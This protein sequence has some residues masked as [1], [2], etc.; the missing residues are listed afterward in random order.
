MNWRLTVA[1]CT[2]G[3][4]LACVVLGQ[5]EKP[6]PADAGQQ[7]RPTAK[8]VG[9]FEPVGAAELAAGTEQ[10]K[11]LVIKQIVPHGTQVKQGQALVW[12]KTDEV[13]KQLEDAET[14]LRLA[15]LKQQEATFTH[16]QFLKIQA[17][18]LGLANR[19]KRDAQQTYDNFVKVDRDQRI[20]S[21]GFNL[22]S[23]K[24]S[25]ENAMEELKQLEKMY[26]E[27]ELTEES[28]EIVLKRAKRSVESAQFRL[29]VAEITAS[30]SLAQVIPRE[31]EQQDDTLARALLTFDKARRGL[32]LDRQR[33][34]IEAAKGRK[35]FAAQKQDVDKMRADRKQMV[36]RAASDGVVY[37]GTLSRGKLAEKPSS[38][39][40]ETTVTNKQ[41]LVTLVNPRALQIRVD[42]PETALRHVKAGGKGIAMPKAFPDRKLEI[43]V[44]SVSLIPMSNG[45]HDC[46][47]NVRLDGDQ[48]AIAA[49]MTCDVEFE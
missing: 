15:E 43:T 25:L 39:A 4:L 49:G 20:A 6:E 17:L 21:T 22:K 12:F 27:D 19:A 45:K 10:I 41:V 48:P 1:T 30:R 3:V 42:L 34:E 8:A 11:S 26:K 5:E 32:E 35:A 13:D 46:V 9:Y 29:K 33:K 16:Q 7:T 24:A 23:S 37:H 28:E 36:L 14:A 40:A 2:L 31:Q 44:K 38:L 47:V 18:D